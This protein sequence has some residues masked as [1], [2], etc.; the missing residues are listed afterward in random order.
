MKSIA[1]N[2][3]AHKEIKALCK[4]LE[5]NIG[6]FVQ[7]SV[8]Y[9]KRTGIDPGKSDN[10]NPHKALKELSKRVEQIIGV[11][12]T[13]EQDKINPL[14]DT[15]MMLV[16]R[17]ELMLN[18]APK[19]TTFKTVLTRMEDIMEEDQKHHSEQLKAQHK[20][21]T[22]S[23]EKLLKNYDQINSKGTKKLDEM[24]VALTAI[25]SVIETKLGKKIF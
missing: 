2:E 8:Q 5:V 19:E 9:F 20:Y 17:A 14:L 7:Y 24:A 16:R 1:I 25:Q 6:E 11:I 21:Y 10:E 13:Q 4:T 15:I 3:Q 18:E 12:K 22:E 23:I